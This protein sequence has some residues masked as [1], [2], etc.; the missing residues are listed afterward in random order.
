MSALR[1]FGYRNPETR[2]VVWSDTKAHDRAIQDAWRRVV[3]PDDEVW[4]LGDL[5]IDS[6][7]QVVEIMSKL[8]GTK[9]LVSGNHD[10]SNT[11]INKPQVAQQKIEEWSTIFDSIQDEAVIEI[12][13][14]MVTLS[15]FPSAEFGDG[16][17]REPGFTPRYMDIRPDMRGGKTI[18]LH[19]HTH[20][21]EKAHGR[22][23]HV[24]L[25]AHGLQLVPEY[26]IITWVESLD[27]TTKKR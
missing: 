13:G 23:Y 18:L 2:Q 22:E 7:P 24:G 5:S 16:D 10:K 26:Q 1:G 15:H 12:A 4:V 19:G 27:S 17:I 8:P 20:G 3:Q 25:D 14:R 9:H 21:T 11:K 6:G